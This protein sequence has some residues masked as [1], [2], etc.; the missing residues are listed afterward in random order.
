MSKKTKAEK[1]AAVLRAKKQIL[2]EGSSQSELPVSPKHV[3]NKPVSKIAPD[4]DVYNPRDLNKTIVV[5]MF[6]VGLLILVYVL[7]YKGYF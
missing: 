1:I 4:A 2:R 6:T 5:T 3:D 7:Q